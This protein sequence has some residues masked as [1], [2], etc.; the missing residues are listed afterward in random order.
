MT[1]SNTE[2]MYRMAVALKQYNTGATRNVDGDKLDI[3]GFL[4]PHAV[5]AYAVYMHKHRKQSDGSMRGSDNWKLGIAIEDYERSLI[6]HCH[7][8][9]RA[10]EGAV[11]LDKNTGEQQSKEDLLCAIIFN[12]MGIL[13][14]R[15]KPRTAEVLGKT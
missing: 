14:E 8:F 6:R 4:S 11:V 10:C 1:T 5:E 12:A 2:G 7:D 13:H 15:N 9:H 3:K